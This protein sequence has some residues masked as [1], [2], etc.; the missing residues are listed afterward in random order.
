MEFK[1][2]K[3]LGFGMMRLPL[4][5][6]AD[7]TSID[8]EQVKKM[9]DLFMERG[10]TYFDT[11]WMYHDF[12]SENVVKEALV[13]RYPRESFTLADKLHSAFFDSPEDMERIFNAQLE[14]TGAGYFDYY[15]MHGITSDRWEKH[16]RMGCLEW[17]ADKKAKGLVKHVGF[18]FHDKADVLDD[19]LTRYP[20]M[21]FVQ[22]Q[23][24]YLDW[25]SPWIQSRLNY[26]VCVK[27]GKPV[28]VMEPVKGGT[29]ADVP[30]EAKEVFAALDPGLSPSAWALRFCAN[31]PNV[32]AVLSGSSTLE[33]LDQNTAC[34]DGFTGF[35]EK[36]LEAC[37]KVADIINS[38]TAV[39]CTGCSYCTTGCPMQIAIP[40]YFS[41]YNEDMREELD[42]KGWTATAITYRKQG[43]V[44]GKPEDCIECGQCESV[45]P[46]HLPIIQYLKDVAAHFAIER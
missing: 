46:Q 29:L 7:Q 35:G 13:D 1:P 41:M 34:I 45:C 8:V 10:F 38:K 28:T 37:A 40:K 30:A 33:Q 27:H 26:E 19:I 9:V 16:E 44:S 2:N 20:E 23:L 36:E 11:A 4:L 42:Q 39:A 18:S 12:K 21:E 31:L 14:K 17:I 32:M 25:E 24:N 15:L 5:D 6:E 3:K 43:E 22:L